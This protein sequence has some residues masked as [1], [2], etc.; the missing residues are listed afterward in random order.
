MFALSY[1]SPFRGHILSI[2][3]RL[4]LKGSRFVE[5]TILLLLDRYDPQLQGL[6]V[7]T[8]NCRV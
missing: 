4:S 2:S 5:S 6:R 1:K 7:Q 3:G 8:D